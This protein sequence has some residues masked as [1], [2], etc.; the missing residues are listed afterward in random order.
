[1]RFLLG[2][3]VL[4]L[5]IYALRF[6]LARFLPSSRAPSTRQNEV[7]SANEAE[8]IV[9]CQQCGTY[10]PASEVIAGDSGM[11]FCSEDHRRRY[12]SAR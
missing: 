5:A 12:F 7:S 4:V 10:V 8:T 2:L 11:V 6:C 3:A 9:R 1:M